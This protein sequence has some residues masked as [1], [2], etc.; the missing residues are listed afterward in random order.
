[1]HHSVVL[2]ESFG[3]NCCLFVACSARVVVNVAL[4]RT[5]YHNICL[6]DLVVFPSAKGHSPRQ[7]SWYSRIL[8]DSIVFMPLTCRQDFYN[9]VL[10]PYEF[11]LWV[12]E[13]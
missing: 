5:E 12:P 1:M 7:I 4:L 6:A 10:V 3:N 9:A 2:R 11:L 8:I 13:L